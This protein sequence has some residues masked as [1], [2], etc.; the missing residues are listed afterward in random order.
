MPAATGPRPPALD[1]PYAPPPGD[2]ACVHADA[3]LLVLVKPAGLLCA[4]G[5]GDDKQDC[6]VSRARRHW[7]DALLVHRLDLATSG[8]VLL[9]RGAEVHAALSAAFRERQVAKAYEALVHGPL[10]GESGEIDL[11]L[12]ADWPRRPLQK[13]CHETG[14]PS[15]TR[16]RWLAGEGGRD[17]NAGA[18]RVA[19]EPVTG[20]SHQLRVHL[21]AIGCPIV[22]D[23]LYGR[24]GDRAPRL[25]LHA[26][27][28]AF[29]H[30]VTGQA[31]E[32]ASPAPF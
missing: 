1:E 23:P 2:P 26:T 17:G 31:L 15:L 7:L 13:V 8:L 3:S 12:A 19:L 4:P 32:L 30:P 27:R 14:K 22:G 20:R 29:R 9:A 6:L 11:P 25:M 28:L 18:D 24:P 21:A 10:P 5:R 16:W